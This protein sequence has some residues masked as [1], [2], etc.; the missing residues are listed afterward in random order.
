[1]LTFGIQRRYIRV[2]FYR[3]IDRKGDHIGTPCFPGVAPGRGS[4]YARHLFTEIKILRK[5]G[6]VAVADSGFAL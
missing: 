5:S 6:I 2:W 4:Q 3:L 1:M